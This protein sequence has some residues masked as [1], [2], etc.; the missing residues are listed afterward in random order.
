MKTHLQVDRRAA[1]KLP[2]TVGLKWAFPPHSMQ[3]LPGD[4]AIGLAPGLHFNHGSRCRTGPS[5]WHS[6]EASHRCLTAHS[7]TRLRDCWA[8]GKFKVPHE[9]NA[10]SEQKVEIT[11]NQL[12]I[13]GDKTFQAQGKR[14]LR[15]QKTYFAWFSFAQTQNLVSAQ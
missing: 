9:G 5:L 15:Q 13:T 1:G 10:F 2:A 8:P 12:R 11:R 4:R 14:S 7:L 3:S 6:T